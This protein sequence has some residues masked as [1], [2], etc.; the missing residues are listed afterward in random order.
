MKHPGKRV[1]DL[2][3]RMGWTQRDL[4]A[5]TGGSVNQPAIHRIESGAA[6]EPSASNMLAIALALGVD[7]LEL[8]DPPTDESVERTLAAFLETPPGREAT[9]EDVA[10]LRRIAVRLGEPT[11]DT[12]YWALKLVQSMRDK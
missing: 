9:P 7:I 1:R 11:T 10:D 12:W 4:A 6:K 3:E 8:Y 5:A 2:R